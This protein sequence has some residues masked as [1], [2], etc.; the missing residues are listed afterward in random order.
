MNTVFD[1]LW[2]TPIRLLY[3]LFTL[4]PWWVRQP[5]DII[6]AMDVL[7]YVWLVI[8]A[9]KCRRDT[10]HNTGTMMMMLLLVGLSTFAIVTSNYGTA[11]PHRAK[12]APYL[13]ILAAPAVPKIRLHFS[14]ETGE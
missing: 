7:L 14:T 10:R 5:I 11:L 12:F 4:Y 2:Q 1:V 13:T 6:G 3:F 8:F 9:W